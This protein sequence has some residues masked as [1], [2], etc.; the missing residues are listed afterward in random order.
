MNPG[1]LLTFLIP[2]HSFVLVLKFAMPF[3]KTEHFT[4]RILP[5]VLV[6][7]FCPLLLK[8]WTCF[9]NG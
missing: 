9:P 8:H 3:S 7:V 2:K 1:T 5:F 4:F 6:Y